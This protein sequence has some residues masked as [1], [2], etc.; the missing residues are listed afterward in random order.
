MGDSR[1]TILST[2]RL[3]GPANR[4][5]HIAA[6]NPCADILERLLSHIVIEATGAAVLPL[7][8]LEYFGRKEP[9]VQLQPAHSQWVIQ[10]LS[11]ARTKPIY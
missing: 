5:K 6:E 7:H 8:L 3:S 4:A 10:V 1:P 9:F 11:W 2:I